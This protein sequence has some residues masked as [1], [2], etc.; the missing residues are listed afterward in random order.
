LQTLSLVPS[1]KSISSAIPTALFAAAALVS[2]SANFTGL[3]AD[4]RNRFL[5][6]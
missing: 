2:T 3:D 1:A 6:T 4:R 5:Q